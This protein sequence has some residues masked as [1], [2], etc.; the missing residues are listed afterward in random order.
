MGRRKIVSDE[1]LLEVARDT[2][3][4]RGYAVPGREIA[5]AAGISEAVL[6]QRF[7]SKD[8]L[9]FAA[10]APA[11]PD[12]VRIFGPRGEEGEATAFLRDALERMAAYFEAVLPLAIPVVQVLRHNRALDG[13]GHET[14]PGGLSERLE[15]ELAVRVRGLQARGAV[16]EGAPLDMARLLVGIAHDHAVGRAILA[17]RSPRAHGPLEAS[18]DLVW[19]GLAPRRSAGPRTRGGAAPARRRSRRGATGG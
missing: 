8:A 2:F 4:E 6:Y 11:E 19:R 3:R 18:V 9:F 17:C 10:M 1:R 12:L 14:G 15:R 16:G 5:K 7:E 13:P